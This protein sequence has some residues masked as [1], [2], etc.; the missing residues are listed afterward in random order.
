MGLSLL[1][2]DLVFEQ[3]RPANLAH[4]KA[5][6]STTSQSPVS[7]RLAVGPVQL[8]EQDLGRDAPISITHD[9][10]D[11]SPVGI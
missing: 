5:Q 2:R 10:I 8:G 1:G 7:V 3:F 11:L 9:F 4:M 6:V